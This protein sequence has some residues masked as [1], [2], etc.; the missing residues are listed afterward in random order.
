VG[1]QCSSASGV[2][3]CVAGSDSNGG[4]GGQGSESGGGGAGGA[5]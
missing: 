5:S 1:Y 3:R 4:A 2:F